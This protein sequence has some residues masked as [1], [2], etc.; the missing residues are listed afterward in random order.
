MTLASKNTDSK[1]LEPGRREFFV[2]VGGTAAPGV[3]SA[4]RTFAQA[5]QSALNIAHGAHPTSQTMASEKRISA[6]ND[7]F[8]PQNSLD[9]NHAFYAVWADPSQGMNQNWVQY[10]W[11]EPALTLRSALVGNM[12]WTS[13]GRPCFRTDMRSIREQPDGS[14]S[15]IRAWIRFLPH[16]LE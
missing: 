14:R 9:R 5:P 12:D 4:S 3:L 10:E 1:R 6:L 2:G 7:G 13:E 15:D 11:G 16:G 8:T